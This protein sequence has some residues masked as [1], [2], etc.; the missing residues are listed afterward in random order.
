MKFV[1]RE[2]S[3]RGSTSIP[4]EVGEETHTIHGISIQGEPYSI[5]EKIRVMNFETIEELLA[6]AKRVND[7]LII[8]TM[9]DIPEIEIYNDYRE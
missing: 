6:F 7:D 2:T 4:A 3:C 5:T 9:N 8:S 1:I